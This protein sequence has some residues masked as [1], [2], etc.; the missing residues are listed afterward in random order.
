MLQSFQYGYLTADVL[1]RYELAIHFL[2]CH[3]SPC[4]NIP[5]AV[6]FSKRALAYAVLLCEHVIS[7]LDLNILVHTLKQI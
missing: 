6:Y 7:H 4:F 2:Y 5:A 3:I 1:L